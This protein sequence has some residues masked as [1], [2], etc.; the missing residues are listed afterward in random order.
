ML[1]ADWVGSVVPVELFGSRAEV[2]VRGISEGVREGQARMEFSPATRQANITKMGQE[3]LDIV[4][5]GGGITGA[6]IARDAA[7]RGLKVALVEKEDFASGTSSKSAR[8]VHGGLRYLEQHQ[9]GLV[10]T[11]CAERHTLC[12]TA[13]RLVRPVSFTF[14]VYRTSKN[15]L[16]KIRMGMW[17][18][19]LM[20]MFHTVQRHKMVDARQTTELEPAL[21]QQDLL[22]AAHYCDCLADDA[23]LTLATIQSAYQHGAL[24]ANYAEVRAMLKENGRVTGAEVIDRVAHQPFNVRARVTVNATGVWAD[25]IRHMDD[26]G[27]DKMIRVNRGS[28]LVLPREKLDIRGAVAFAS[29]DGRRAMYAIPWRR[30]CIVG[31]TDIDHGGELDQVYATPD[32]V[33]GMLESVNQA[34]PDARL[35]HADIIS[36]FAGLRPL[37]GGE[38]SVAY[39]ASR[40]H[41]IVESDAGL[42]TISGGKLTTYR[43]MAE[44]LVDLV[45]GKLEA[46]W[47]V[48][49]REKCKT[50]RIPLAESGFEVGAVVNDLAGRYPQ[51]ERPVLEHV[52]FAYGLAGAGLLAAL[53]NDP[54]LGIKVV[55]R[56][57]YIW[58]EVPYAIQHEMAMT[59]CDWMIRRTHIMHEDTAQGLGCAAEVAAMMAPYLGW[60]AAEVERQTQQYREQVMLSQRYRRG[61]AGGELSGNDPMVEKS[62]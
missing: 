36:T 41:H 20:A 48:M 39:Q 46:A 10:F 22:G 47:G 37:V 12:E 49:T 17:L 26:A 31:T 56:L 9:F 50:D 4:V 16:L 1:F 27:A 8:M 5:I 62:A 2:T 28:H 60:D 34:F 14:P 52:A 57:P 11:A 13:P 40:D 6:G 32:E 29:A 51:L 3:P 54:R 59:L 18:Y 42:V 55:P 35:T 45:S 21:S 44:D 25:Q 43:R 61:P 33:V 23:R 7:M 58:A 24:V 30:T 15:S 19:D 38:E 53:E